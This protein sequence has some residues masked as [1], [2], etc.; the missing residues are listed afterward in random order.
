MSKIIVITGPE[1]TGKSTLASQ[2]A[3]QFT[4][5]LVQEYAR[6]YVDELDRSYTKKDLFK[7]AKGQYE[8]QVEALKKEAEIIILDTSL[9]NIKI[10]ST[11]KYGHCHHGILSRLEKQRVDGWILCGTEIPWEFDP[12]R[13]N[14][15]DREELYQ[16][17]KDELLAIKANI[18]MVHGD[19]KARFNKS[20]DWI[21]QFQ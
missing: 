15:N 5:T 20:V 13:E 11:F 10:W 3:K 6:Q 14:P 18:L 21:K 17:F 8:R 12:Q 1:S 9:L 19:K 4:A 7:I 16:L 2:L